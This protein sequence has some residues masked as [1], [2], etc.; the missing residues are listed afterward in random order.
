MAKK[1]LVLLNIGAA[2][3]KDEL[4]VF[5]TNI[6]NNK[7]IIPIGN[8]TARSMT[9]S[10]FLTLSLEKMWNDYVSSEKISSLHQLTEKLIE[11][12]APL[13]PEYYITSAMLYTSPFSQTAVARIKKEK[14]KDVV[15]LPLYPH[16]SSITVQSSIDDFLLK[17]DNKFRIKIIEPFYKND[18]YNKSICD[19]IIRVQGKYNDFHLLFSVH[20]LPRRFINESDSYEI[21]IEEHIELLKDKLSYY[22]TNLCSINLAYQ[23]KIGLFKSLRPSLQSILK[24]FKNKKVIIYPLSFILDNSE[25]IYEL[26]FK[27]RSLA[28]SYGIKEMRVCS[29]VNDN[30][31]FVKALQEIVSLEV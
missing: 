1:A 24:K 21:Q 8:D 15:L 26:D 29:C 13:L 10:L 6:F 5:L 4:E 23:S 2:R 14:I 25:T 3:N 22:A 30:T 16:Y 31:T 11:K 28:D 18:M 27:Y 7:R 12:L 9:A 19:E 20:N 17:A